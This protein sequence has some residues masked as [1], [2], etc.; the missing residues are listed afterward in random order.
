MKLVERYMIK[1][2]FN[3]KIKH[4]KKMT[5]EIIAKRASKRESTHSEKT[6][7]AITAY[8]IYEKTDLTRNQIYDAVARDIGLNKKERNQLGNRLRNYLLSSPHE[9]NRARLNVKIIEAYQSYEKS[10][11]EPPKIY[12]RMQKDLNFPATKRHA[13]RNVVY[14]YLKQKRKNS[15]KPRIL[16]HA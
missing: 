4:P 6:I 8:K 5:P 12:D 10:G 11:M 3:Y 1:P 7:L 2:T 13:M 16:V 14:E 9:K 15:K